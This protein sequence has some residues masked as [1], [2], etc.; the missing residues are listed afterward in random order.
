MWIVLFII[1][2]IV[3]VLFFYFRQIIFADK[4][5]Y[6]KKYKD[7]F[8]AHKAIGYPKLTDDQQFDILDNENTKFISNLTQ[9][10]F[11][12]AGLLNHYLNIDPDDYFLHLKSQDLQ[13]KLGFDSENLTDGFYIRHDDENYEYIFVERQHIEFKKS[14]NSYDQL[15]KYLVYARLKLYAPDKYKYLDKKYYA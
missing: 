6:E 15:L 5:N 12:P 8:D 11:V 10:K 7:I 2:A 4:R 3:S 13:R 14:F 1:L 9:F